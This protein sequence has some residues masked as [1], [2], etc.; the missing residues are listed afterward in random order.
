[1]TGKSHET[2]DDKAAGKHI[3]APPAD[4]AE[5]ADFVFQPAGEPAPEPVAETK[6]A[7]PRAKKATEPAEPVEDDNGEVWADEQT[8]LGRRIAL[9]RGD[10]A[11]L[12]EILPH[13]SNDTHAEAAKER[14]RSRIRG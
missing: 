9:I 1:M 14:L 12:E 10:G 6:P 3:P 5:P 7:K 8:A 2:A 11:T 4:D 13:G